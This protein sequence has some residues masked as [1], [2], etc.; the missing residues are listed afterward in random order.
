MII[1]DSSREKDRF[2]SLLTLPLPS[3]AVIT[4]ALVDAK[5]VINYL[6]ENALASRH[7]LA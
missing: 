2:F 7:K 6:L 4:S 5:T 3:P 1:R